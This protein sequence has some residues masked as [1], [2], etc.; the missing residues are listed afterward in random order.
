MLFFPAAQTTNAQEMS[1]CSL[2]SSLFEN[3]DYFTDYSVVIILAVFI[4]ASLSW[5]ISARHWFTGP[6]RNIDEGA[7]TETLGEQ[8]PD[9]DEKDGKN[10]IVVQASEI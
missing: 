3:T 8:S 1:E 4:F 9:Y 5:V 6:V 7:S 10:E 2:G